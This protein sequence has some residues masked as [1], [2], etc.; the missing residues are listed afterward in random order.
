MAFVAADADP[1]AA[2]RCSPTHTRLATGK[3]ESAIDAKEPASLTAMAARSTGD[4]RTCIELTH[5]VSSTTAP[6]SDVAD[7]VDVIARRRAARS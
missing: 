7:A 6:P 4:L 1:D 5:R 2:R 3:R